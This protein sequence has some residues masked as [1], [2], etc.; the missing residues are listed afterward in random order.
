[1][2]RRPL[3]GLLNQLPIV[4]DE[5]VPVSGIRIGRGNGSILRKPVLAP[6]CPSQI[7]HYLTWA[8][9]RATAVVDYPPELWHGPIKMSLHFQFAKR[10][11]IELGIFSSALL[12]FTV[13]G[14]FCSFCCTQHIHCYPIA[15]SQIGPARVFPSSIATHAALRYLSQRCS[16]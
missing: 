5:C 6:L 13:F 9:T 14:P 3:I 8:R 7:P 10:I 16:R 2:V 4:D 11:N 15:V 1:L 12:C